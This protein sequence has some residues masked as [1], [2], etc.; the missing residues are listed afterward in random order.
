[1]SINEILYTMITL[2]GVLLAHSTNYAGTFKGFVQQ[3]A[4]RANRQL[5]PK[6]SYL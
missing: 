2:D 5:Q 4:E 3:V 1:M 6:Q